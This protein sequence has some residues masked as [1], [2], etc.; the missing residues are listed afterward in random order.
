MRT[1]DWRLAWENSTIV[2][3]HRRVLCAL[4]CSM[5]GD[6][7]QSTVCAPNLWTIGRRSGYAERTARRYVRQVEELG[8]VNV[9]RRP[10]GRNRYYAALPAGVELGVDDHGRPDSRDTP[11]ARE[12]ASSHGGE[13][14]QKAAPAAVQR[15][16]LIEDQ[17]EDHTTSSAEGPR[18]LTCGEPTRPFFSKCDRCIAEE[19]RE[20]ARRDAELQ[21]RGRRDDAELRRF[22]E[23][24][25]R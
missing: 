12:T 14:V 19:S 20:A 23:A 22:A 21:R 2:A 6:G 24:R 16:D 17:E 11:A 9:G 15:A 8:W 13:A 1:V 3:Q 18:C 7:G 4:A 10:G 25:D 5:G